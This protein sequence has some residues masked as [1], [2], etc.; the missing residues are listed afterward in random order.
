MGSPIVS[1]TFRSFDGG[2]TIAS[3]SCRPDH[4]SHWQVDSESPSIARGAGLSYAAASF[5]ANVLST[6]HT[7]RDRVVAF[8]KVTGVL[9]VE[10]GARLGQ[11]YDFLTPRG[12][13]LPVQPGHPSI[14]I[15]G[16]IAGDVHGKNQARDG[17]FSQLVEGLTL[18][19]RDHGRLELAAGSAL[20][21]LTCGAFGLTGD[22][23]SAGLR[24]SPIPSNR[25]EVRTLPLLRVEDLPATLAEVAGEADLLYSWHDFTATGKRFGRG[26]VVAGRFVDGADRAASAVTQTSKLRAETRGAKRP[27]FFNRLTTRP[28][29][30]MFRAWTMRSSAPRRVALYEFLFPVHNKELY[31]HLFGRGGFHEQQLLIPTERFAAFAEGIRKLQTLHAMPITLASGKLFA[32]A[33]KLLCFRGAGIAFAIN[34]PRCARSAEFAAHVDALCIELGALPNL[35][36]DSRLPAEVARQC[37]P[38]YEE[39]RIRLHEFDPHRRYRSELSTRLDL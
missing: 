30:A 4:E 27:R 38:G 36:K 9:E 8:D 24:V 25:I 31:F 3:R 11:V 26:F 5:G 12:F 35:I 22:I 33:G 18:L 2:S 29:N 14:T 19:H 13:Y 17:T 21:D 28:F 39:F 1:E 6:D 34:Y 37:H 15:G 7:A 16:C 20:C 23:L 32:G 10:A